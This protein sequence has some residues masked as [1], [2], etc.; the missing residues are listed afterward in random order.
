MDGAPLKGRTHLVEH[1]ARDACC[2]RPD[3]GQLRFMKGRLPEPVIAQWPLGVRI[4]FWLVLSALLW[5]GII[6]LV[7]ALTGAT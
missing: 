4:G 1:A 3:D 7:L 6:G 2:W 5:T